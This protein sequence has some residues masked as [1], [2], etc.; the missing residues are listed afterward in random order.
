MKESILKIIWGI[1]L[2]SRRCKFAKK[3]LKLTEF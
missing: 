3:T 2:L 1:E